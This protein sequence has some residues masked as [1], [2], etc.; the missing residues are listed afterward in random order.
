MNYLDEPI[1]ITPKNID[2]NREA[3]ESK[4]YPG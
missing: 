2:N 4:E 3:E 1:R